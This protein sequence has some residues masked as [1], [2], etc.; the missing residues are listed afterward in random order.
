MKRE[1]DYFNM[2]D[3]KTSLQEQR[4]SFDNHF[5]SF[6]IW[7][8]CQRCKLTVVPVKNMKIIYYTKY[9]NIKYTFLDSHWRYPFQ[10]YKGVNKKG[11]IGCDKALW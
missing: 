2:S 9:A 7:L 8:H 10:G 4:Y 11:I 5:S 1:A 3:K 6:G